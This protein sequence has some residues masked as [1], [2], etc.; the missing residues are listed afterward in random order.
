MNP[1]MILR[2]SKLIST[3][4][5][6]IKKNDNPINKPR[7]CLGSCK[8]LLSEGKDRWPIYL[9]PVVGLL[10]LVWFIIRVIPKPSRA[11]YPCQRIAGSFASGFIIWVAGLISSTLAYRKARRLFS[12]SRFIIAGLFFVMSV[13]ILWISMSKTIEDPAIAAFAPIDP[14]NS[15]IGVAK[16]IYPGR[17]AWIHEPTATSWDGLT[18][19]WWDDNNTNQ[20]VVDFMVSQAIQTLT[21]QP[22][23]A[24]AWDALFRHFNKNNGFHETGYQ[25]GEKIAIKINMNQDN[26]EEWGQGQG[27]PSPHVIY[28]LLGQLINVVNIPGEAITIYDVSRHIG[29][30]IYN[31]IHINPDPNFQSVKFVSRVGEHGRIRATIDDKNLIYTR[32]GICHLPQCISDAKYLI[33]MALLR[34]HTGFGVTLTA[35]NHFGSI[36]FPGEGWTPEPLHN[37]GLKENPMGSY[38]CLVNLNGH[39]HLGGKTLLY[40]IDGLYPSRH[41]GADVIKWI[42]F[43][44]D[45]CSS[46]FISQ[47]QVAIDSVGLDFLWYEGELNHAINITGNPDNYLH[48]AALA[49][50][51][52]S[53]TVYDPEGDGTRLNSLGVHEHWNNPEDKQYSRNLGTGDGIELARPSFTNENGPIENVNRGKRYDYFRYAI[54]EAEPGDLIIAGPGIYNED[55]NFEG[56]NLTLSSVDPND[57]AI[58]AATIIS[59]SKQA[60]TFSSGEG[61]N[62]TLSGFIISDANTGIYC[63]GS[64]PFISKCCIIENKGA[65]I[66]LHNGSNPIISHCKI[67]YNTGTGIEMYEKQSEL[68]VTYTYPTIT[69]CVISEN[70]RHGISGGIP[71]ITNCTI[72]ANNFHGIFKGIPT[73]TNSIIY[74]NNHDA[75]FIQID[76]NSATISYSDIQNNWPGEDNFNEDPFF[77]AIGYWDTNNTPDDPNDS[78]WHVGDYHL[79]SQAGRWDPNSKTWISD[80]VTSPCIDAGNPHS[81]YLL[82]PLPN[83]ERINIGAYGGTQKASMSLLYANNRINF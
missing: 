77:V 30:P 76:C 23:D 22:N 6:K 78:V 29:D 68:L 74:F 52:P 5:R 20:E 38:N 70:N 21:N 3:V 49:G 11:T 14:P 27:M 28:S 58:V 16:G 2:K 51:P 10:S 72:A 81:D 83:G 64:S 50:N 34:P 57:P 32:A 9:L 63:S 71:T 61:L 73:V 39:K 82:E 37:Y 42:S 55:V 25:P 36:Y 69:N 15:P 62:C 56:K 47:D 13:I 24:N 35:K 33:N 59:G 53:G 43:G 12:Q 75:D 19:D 65:G 1:P 45:W 17:V 7:F 46:I 44:D 31:K 8:H 40:L 79:Q 54:M 60:V 48:E 67:I 41:Q 4:F 18:G 80:P 26:G 66:G